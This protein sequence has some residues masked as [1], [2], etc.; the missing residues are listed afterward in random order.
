MKL[1]IYIDD[2]G[3]VIE[4]FNDTP[5]IRLEQADGFVEVQ[6]LR[7]DGNETEVTG[8]YVFYQLVT[9]LKMIKAAM[10]LVPKRSKA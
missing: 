1:G 5:N 3:Q 10:K 2:N 9:D 6:T 4:I 8:S 7:N